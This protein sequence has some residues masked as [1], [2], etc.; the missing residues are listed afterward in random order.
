MS[1]KNS[2]KRVV[3]PSCANP[4]RLIHSHLILGLK[5]CLIGAIT[6]TATSGT[7]QDEVESH[8]ALDGVDRDPVLR[9][10]YYARGVEFFYYKQF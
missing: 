7:S 2:N 1:F 10:L 9:S 4:K 5:R 3:K 6:P 8:D